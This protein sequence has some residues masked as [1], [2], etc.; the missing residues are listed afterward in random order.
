MLAGQFSDLLVI[1]LCLST[2]YVFL[3]AN[4]LL[5]APLWPL[6]RLEGEL[7]LDGILW[8]IVNL[9]VHVTTVVRLLRDELPVKLSEDKLALWRMFFRTGGVSQRVFQKTVAQFCSVVSYEQDSILDTDKYFFIVYKGT[10]KL[11][12]TDDNGATISTRQAQSGQLFDFRAL[13]LLQ[14][15]QSL[16]KHQLQAVVTVSKVTLFRFRK[17]QIA[18]IANNPVTRLM[19]KELL[20]ENMLRIVQ[21]YFDRRV[22]HGR[23]SDFYINPIFAPLNPS[24]EPHPLRAGSGK[25]L[26]TPLAHI[27]ASAQW[28]FAP[29]YPFKGPPM[30]LRHNNLLAP[31]RVA[32]MPPK[33]LLDAN[34]T[35]SFLSNGSGASQSS[36]NGDPDVSYQTFTSAEEDEEFLEYLHEIDEEMGGIHLVGFKRAISWKIEE[37]ES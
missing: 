30:G 19:W 6:L 20:M 5:G 18:S 12:V 22:R 16:A 7:Q 17:D 4:S 29:P 37:E 9:Y 11:T 33:R 1:R 24:E 32:N 36:I 13:G 23:S 35:D 34:E 26:R 31:G 8:A 3:F 27:F 15:N 14:D 25:A 28:S 2:A 10:V 21:R